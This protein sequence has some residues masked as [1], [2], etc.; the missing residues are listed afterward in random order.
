M[1][2]KALYHQK[3][4]EAIKNEETGKYEELKPIAKAVR[5]RNRRTR[6]EDREEEDKGATKDKQL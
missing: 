2:D 3:G 6:R 5:I 1:S 4:F